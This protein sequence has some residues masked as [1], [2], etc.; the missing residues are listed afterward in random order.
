MASGRIS[1]EEA[2]AIAAVIE[3]QRRALETEQLEA[4]MIAIEESLKSNEQKQH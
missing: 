3:G 1:T 2:A 4:R